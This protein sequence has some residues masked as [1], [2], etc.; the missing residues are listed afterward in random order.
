V[1]GHLFPPYFK[2]WWSD[3]W[4]STVYGAEHTFLLPDVQIKHNV[5]AQKT[6]GT[7]RYEVD[8]V[9]EEGKGKEEEGYS[10]Y[11]LRLPRPHSCI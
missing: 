8:K 3:D 1:F 11:C 9:I 7:T 6:K 2:N 5:G 4:I 10:I